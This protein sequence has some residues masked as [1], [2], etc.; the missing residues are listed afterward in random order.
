M[1]IKLFTTL[2]LIISFITFNN[3]SVNA[4]TVCQKYTLITSGMRTKYY[5]F[6][7]DFSNS[8]SFDAFWQKVLSINLSSELGYVLK[9]ELNCQYTHVTY[10]IDYNWY[11]ARYELDVV[12]SFSIRNDLY[13]FINNYVAFSSTTTTTTTTTT[14][15]STTTTTTTS[16]PTTTTT[17]LPSTTTTTTT[18]V[19]TTTTTT[20]LQTTT[21]TTLAPTTTT[22]TTSTTTIPLT[23]TTTVPRPVYLIPVTTTTV[24]VSSN[25][26]TTTIAQVSSFGQNPSVFPLAPKPIYYVKVKKHKYKYFFKRVLVYTPKRGVKWNNLG[27]I[28]IVCTNNTFKRMSNPSRFFKQDPTLCGTSKDLMLAVWNI[29][30]TT[31][32]Y[33]NKSYK[34]I[35]YKKLVEYWTYEPYTQSN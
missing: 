35:R 10:K 3:S 20:V 28:G 8:D 34:K 7:K 21:T 14:L 9:N 32:I 22:T 17:T 29:N 30:N 5:M 2:A 1:K 24:P 33:Y 25:V 12:S 15:P 31:Q 19:P 11:P 18:L 13:D 4:S 27:L 16:P 6:K 23:T 26:T